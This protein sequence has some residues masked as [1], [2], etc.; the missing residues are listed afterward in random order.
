MRVLYIATS[1]P[2]PTKGATI[3]TDLAEA[4]NEAG[5]EI[6][7]AV[8]EQS[9]N[10]KSTEMKKERGFD[11]LRVVTGN[12]YDVGYIEKGITSLKI[13][14]LMRKGIKKYLGDRIFDLILFEA[15][16]VTNA[17]LV[18]WAKKNFSCP[19]YLMLKDIFPQN[20]V[21][22]GILK[23]N[24]LLYRY[25][26]AKEKKLLKTADYI[27][28][29][30]S[31]NKRYI[32]EHNSWLNPQNIEIFP[33]T[34]KLTGSI[35]PISFPMRER[36]GIPKEACVFLFGGNMGR[37]QYIDLLCEVIKDCKDEKEMYFLFVGRGTDRP[38][39]EQTIKENDINNALVIENLPRTEYEQITKECDIGL[40]VLDPRFTIP[41]YPSRILA[42]MEY[43]KPVIAAIDKVTDLKEMIEKAN[44]GEW[45]WSG[46]VQSVINKAKEMSK[47]ERLSEMGDNGRK[48]LESEF[49]VNR[50]VEILE[51]HF[52]KA[53]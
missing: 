11:V 4:L 17:G 42:Y 44:C 40:I 36:Y 5:H 53:R 34:K 2:E 37:P 49:N 8:S 29:M 31:E 50:S 48:Y 45:V 32:V 13:P 22:L 16:P 24:G 10:K 52:G 21:D 51:N 18:D 3:Y 38:K 26:K 30:S 28:C 46:D 35:K 25:F 19:S 47:S 14:V 15:P 23:R 6:T 12:Y 20:A 39:L 7:V 9:R 27:G 33:N 43:A 41:N 1:F